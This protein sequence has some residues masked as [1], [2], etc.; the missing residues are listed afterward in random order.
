M[1]KRKASEMDKPGFTVQC[2]AKTPSPNESRKRPLDV[3]LD[4]DTPGPAELQIDYSIRPGSKWNGMR[5]YRNVKYQENDFPIDTFILVN[6][7]YPPP[8]PPPED[9]T[10]EQILEYQRTNTWVGKIQET[11]AEDEHR[12]FLRV[13]WLYWPQELPGGRRAYHGQQ[14]LVLS[15]HVEVVE[16]T[17]ISGRA[18]VSHWTEEDDDDDDERPLYPLFWRQTLDLKPGPDGKPT[19][20]ALRKHCV[21]RKEYNPD[22]IMFKCIQDSCGIWNH[23]ECLEKDLESSL[24]LKLRKKALH[25]HLDRR[26]ADFS[27]DQEQDDQGSKV[28]AGPTGDENDKSADGSAR[29]P[30]PL[31]TAKLKGKKARAV[32]QDPKE[33]KLQVTVQE[34]RDRVRGTIVARVKLVPG[35]GSTAEV[36][37]WTI[38]VN[39]LKCFHPLE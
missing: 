19:L 2:P 22:N 1:P 33:D 35:K 38:K 13:F 9:A 6:R 12:V 14:E 11:R 4:S 16:A 28:A 7:T 25:S 15:N 3:F 32:Q 21:C 29:L 10:H 17:T 30:P 31:P 8:S 34:L 20:S 24:R 5:R 37:E 23:K 18:E 39:C 26:A 36:K 27:H